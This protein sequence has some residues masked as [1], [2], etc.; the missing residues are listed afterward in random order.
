MMEIIQPNKD[1]IRIVGL[2]LEQRLT[3]EKFEKVTICGFLN[4]MCMPMAF[5][6]EATPQPKE[7]K[8]PAPS[9]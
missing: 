9:A 4:A 7:D 6:P 2:Y 5:V 8:C 3:M 1:I